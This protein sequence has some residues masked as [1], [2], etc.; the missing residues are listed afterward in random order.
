MYNEII[1]EEYV[2]LDQNFD[3]KQ[4]VIR[5]ISEKAVEFGIADDAEKT[6]ASMII[7]EN[8][9]STGLTDGF[10]IPHSRNKSIKKPSVI[11]VRMDDGIDWGTMD[12][13]LVNIAIA[14]LVPKNNEDNTHMRLISQLSRS[15]MKEDFRARL[16][17]SQDEFEVF[18]LF[19]EIFRKEA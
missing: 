11:V 7:R 13:S 3:N 6:Y 2:F 12:D 5:F 10:A 15:L 17:K 14:I 9:V 4:S 16:S 18:Q 1:K 8:E 19:D